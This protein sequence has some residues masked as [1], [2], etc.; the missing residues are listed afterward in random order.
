MKSNTTTNALAVAAAAPDGFNEQDADI[1]MYKQL[2]HVEAFTFVSNTTHVAAATTAKRMRESG[3]HKRL[4]L[5]WDEFCAKHLCASRATVDR[6]ISEVTELGTRAYALK[7]LLGLPK[8]QVALLQGEVELKDEGV[9]I[10]GTVIAFNKNNA[11]KIR[12]YVE[13]LLEKVRTSQ[14]ET[15]AAE[16]KAA[17]AEKKASEQAAAAKAERAKMAELKRRQDEPFAGAGPLRQRLLKAQS[18]ATIAADQLRETA[19]LAQ[20]ENE[21]NEVRSLLSHI[22]SLLVN[23]GDPDC[24]VAAFMADP[25]AARNLLAEFA[26]VRQ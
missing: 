16:A 26:E 15:V 6:M 10:D 2:G 22:V 24:P 4:N 18:Y 13:G 7:R 1:A 11:P 9:V 23:A 12:D 25:P 20:D 8:D 21:R 3:F 14:S 17:K 5:T 19:A